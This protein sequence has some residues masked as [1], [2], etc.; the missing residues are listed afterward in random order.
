MMF[1]VVVFDA[2]HAAFVV[3]DAV[4]VRLVA[5]PRALSRRA[6][7]RLVHMPYI[8]FEPMPILASFM[9]SHAL[10]TALDRSAVPVAL[11]SRR[12]CGVILM[13]M[14]SGAIPV[15]SLIALRSSTN[16]SKLLAWIRVPTDDGDFPLRRCP[17]RGPE[18]GDGSCTPVGRALQKSGDRLDAAVKFGSYVY[19]RGPCADALAV[20]GRRRHQSV[21]GDPEVPEAFFPRRTPAYRNA[22]LLCADVLLHYPLYFFLPEW[23]E[24]PD[25]SS[26]FSRFCTLQT[27]KNFML[28]NNSL[29]VK[30][31][32]QGVFIDGGRSMDLNYG[33]RVADPQYPK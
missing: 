31:L 32:S 14:L 3:H 27:Y 16:S 12:G 17:G 24:N 11:A 33:F 30:L 1:P 20:R 10:A 28:K 9:F 2:D 15:R 21:K 6:F 23:S 26:F 29:E 4:G 18:H 8:I 7:A 13:R 22:F 5:R 25:C 19:F